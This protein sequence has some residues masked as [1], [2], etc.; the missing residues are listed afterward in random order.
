MLQHP[1]PPLSDGTILLRPWTEQDLPALEQASRDPYIPTIT[2]VP[3]PY[4]YAEG[5][6]W[7]ERQ[8][9]RALENV[10]LPFCIADAQKDEPIGFIGL[11]LPNLPQGRAH[12]G[13]WMI[14]KSRRRG[15]A[16]AALRLLS[17]WTFAHLPVAR[18]ELWVELWNV[19]SQRVA[20]RAG[21]LREGILHSYIE[22]EK[23]RRDVIMYARIATSLPIQK[24]SQETDVPH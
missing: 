1:S 12:F 2:S 10:G 3:S 8:H 24:P 14:P 23:T 20:E 16:S 11:W 18:L 5:L 22:V 19:A 17:T 13:Y 15:M 9:Q 6:K 7:L 4:T 21:F